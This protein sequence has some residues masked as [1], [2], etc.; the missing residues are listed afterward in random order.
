MNY[1]L[2]RESFVCKAQPLYTKPE[3]DSL[4]SILSNHFLG[5]DRVAQILNENSEIKQDI[6]TKF[7][8]YVHRLNNHEPI[9]YITNTSEFYG[10]SFYVNE[11]V[12]I[13]RPETE[14][15]V[16]W[17]LSQHQTDHALRI[18][19]IGTG[20][21][22][23]PIVLSKKRPKWKIKALDF[24]PEALAVAMKNSNIHTAEVEFFEMD[25]LN[26]DLD[27]FEPF[28]I[29]VSNPPYV[30]KSEKEKM[31]KQVFEYEPPTA[32]FVSD[33]DPFVF[34]DRIADL[35]YKKLNPSGCL[36]FEINEF[37]HKEI[38]SIVGSFGFKCQLK[39][40]I[41]GKRRMLKG[42]LKA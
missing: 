5:W 23:I 32:L 42:Q 7:D 12:L 1:R 37:H 24:C 25:V 30:L 3:A 31:T 41:S 39:N 22:C 29:I 33:Q 26:C 35:G 17:I 34:Y 14:E 19:D 4:F 9:E 16:E 27:I 8:H 40:D 13:P 18:L 38:R 21:G 11:D 2:L 20:S 6:E 10:Y 15:L 28:D 36:Y